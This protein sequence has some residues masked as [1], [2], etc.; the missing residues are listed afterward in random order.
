MMPDLARGCDPQ[1]D[2]AA[3]TTDSQAFELMINSEGLYR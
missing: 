1:G 2:E 3:Q